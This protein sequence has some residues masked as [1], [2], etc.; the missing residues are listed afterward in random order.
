[1]SLVQRALFFFSFF[2]SDVRGGGTVVEGDI[3]SGRLCRSRTRRRE[4]GGNATS[5]QRGGDLFWRQTVRVGR[6]ENST[7]HGVDVDVGPFRLLRPSEA[8]EDLLAPETTFF[9]RR[10]KRVKM[11]NK[12]QRERQKGTTTTGRLDYERRVK[13][14]GPG[15]SAELDIPP[16]RR[17][18][19]PP[20]PPPRHPR[21]G[22]QT[23]R[24]IQNI[25][26]RK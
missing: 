12:R 16:M 22:D 13:R 11:A 6:T 19:I 15:G 24:R 9:G 2:F 10:T 21:F 25:S 17:G 26:R 18:R 4:R 23:R 8:E 20:Y 7:D 3:S 1:M 14:Q 5:E